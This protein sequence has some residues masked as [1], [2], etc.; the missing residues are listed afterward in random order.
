VIIGIGGAGLLLFKE[1]AQDGRT[2]TEWLDEI[3][4]GDEERR[5]LALEMIHEMGPKAGPALVAALTNQNETARARA[6]RLIGEIGRDQP[7]AGALLPLLS[8]SSADVRRSA[9]GALGH[10][11]PLSGEVKAGLSALLQDDDAMVRI[12]AA[13]SLA[14]SDA[15][16]DDA[17]S[18]VRAEATSPVS[19]VRVEAVVALGTNVS[20]R[21]TR[22]PPCDAL[23]VLRWKWRNETRG[24]SQRM[25]HS[26]ATR[27]A[28]G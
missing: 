11:Q 25:P 7:I 12:T 1:P 14:G 24:R 4:S 8:D 9:A 26:A 27:V 21:R 19:S 5:A 22:S 23:P 18:T 16:L 13:S 20:R 28:R 15:D 2:L 6:A 17:F 10:G 3:A